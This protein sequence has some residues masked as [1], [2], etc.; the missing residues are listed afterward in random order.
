MIRIRKSVVAVWC[1][2]GDSAISDAE[3]VAA[4]AAVGNNGRDVCQRGG[5]LI[6]KTNTCRFFLAGQSFRRYS[7]F[8]QVNLNVKTSLYYIKVIIYITCIIIK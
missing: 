2:R 6:N 3:V 4:A 8:R 1:G 7:Q 5:P